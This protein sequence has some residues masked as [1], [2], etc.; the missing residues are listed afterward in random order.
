MAD[1]QVSPKQHR[2]LA[3][4]AAFVVLAAIFA[5]QALAA[6][7]SRIPCSEAAEVT[8][9]V[10]FETLISE[11]FSHK[12][13]AP[14]IL[15]ESLIDEISIVSPISVLAPRAAEAIRDAFAEIDI[16]T[17]NS[18]VADPSNGALAP[19]VAGAEPKT[20]TSEAEEDETVSGMNAKLPGFS[21]DA[22]LR[23]KKRMFRRDI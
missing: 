13:P 20:E 14:S 17:A 22:M 8:L 19:P 12:V 9:S 3:A 18:P 10:A 11:T 15:G 16:A 6:T 4:N 1:R 21:D 2:I 23:Y 5:V 7:S